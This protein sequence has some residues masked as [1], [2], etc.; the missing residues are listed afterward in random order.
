MRLPA[1]RALLLL[2]AMVGG[3]LV[4]ASLRAENTL[5]SFELVQTQDNQLEVVVDSDKTPEFQT[6]QQNGTVSITLKN[7]KLSD[8]QLKHGM[9]VILDNKAQYIGRAVPG[10]N[11][12]VKIVLPNVPTDQLKINVRH[13]NTT[14][15]RRPAPPV[16]LQA[17]AAQPERPTSSQNAPRQGLAV[18]PTPPVP[19]SNGWGFTLPVM[20]E[21]QAPT[22]GNTPYRLT[23][24]RRRHAQRRHYTQAP[25]WTTRQAAPAR[26]ATPQRPTRH[27][28]PVHL[29]TQPTKPAMAPQQPTAKAAP[30]EATAMLATAAA[31][32]KGPVVPSPVGQPYQYHA[33]GPVAR[34]AVLAFALADLAPR[35][36]HQKRLFAEPSRRQLWTNRFAQISPL[37]TAAVPLLSLASLPVAARANN[38]ALIRQLASPDGPIKV[39]KTAVNP[40][41]EIL[42][43]MGIDGPWTAWLPWVFAALVG[44]GLLGVLVMV[45]RAFF[46]GANKARQD[47]M[48]G[49][50]SA[51]SPASQVP[52]AGLPAEADPQSF[53][54]ASAEFWS[55]PQETWEPYQATPSVQP[56]VVY[57]PAPVSPVVYP[58]PT[59]TPLQQQ[60]YAQPQ[61]AAADIPLPLDYTPTPEEMAAAQ[62][63]LQSS[64]YGMIPGQPTAGESA[65]GLSSEHEPPSPLSEDDFAFEAPDNFGP[66]QGDSAAHSTESLSV[67]MP[68]R[69]N[70]ITPPLQ[71][72]NPVLTSKDPLFGLVV[73]RA[74]QDGVDYDYFTT[75]FSA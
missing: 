20:P 75:R 32:P 26:A 67:A 14:A 60:P 52:G 5:N 54:D 70:L 2:M 58:E 6:Q 72:H 19:K 10:P 46:K 44:A 48:I 13:K 3:T 11:G 33:H 43:G 59:I 29:A 23:Y 25:T 61:P 74:A 53:E 34:E 62:A 69:P 37:L 63:W 39:A 15:Q 12:Q 38:E 65:Y 17:P 49:L 21:L 50:P 36:N 40:L 24:Q 31:T 1:S 55:E 68:Q 41:Q 47:T 22:P 27:R 4:N 51:N 28:G 9:P 66:T 16:A 45:G 42:R 57:T 73:A 8:K 35:S 56:D 18:L 7:T 71:F 30:T 64:G